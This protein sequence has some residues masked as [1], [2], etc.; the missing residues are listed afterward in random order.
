M[1]IL[2]AGLLAIAFA[3]TI[4]S[5]IYLVLVLLAVQPSNTPAAAQSQSPPISVLKP[6]HGLEPGLEHNLKS[7]F[8]QDYPGFEIIFGVRALSDPALEA[9]TRLSTQFPHVRVKVVAGGEPLWPSARAWSVHRMIPEAANEIL[10]IT[11]SDVRVESD[12]LK[13]VHAPLS[14]AG[15]V[16][17]LY[18]GLPLGGFW[19]HLEA[20]GMSVELMSG[21]LVANMLE[22]MKFA[23]GPATA[24][25]KQA[26]EAIGGMEEPGRHFADDFV[27]GGRM[28]ASGRA[29][30]L[31]DH[32]VEHAVPPCS[33]QQSFRHQLLWAKSS[34][35]SR[36]WGHIGSGLTFAMPYAILGAAVIHGWVALAWVG[37]GAANRILQCLAAGW[38]VVRDPRAKRLCWLYPVRD[39]L[40]WFVWICSFFGRTVYFRGGKYRLTRTGSLMPID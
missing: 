20:L 16:T 30:V 7:F 5:S 6:L 37:L 8:E 22:G 17:C 40:G 29:V 38:G 39:L 1:H 15:L 10:V 25:T 21:V 27:L 28:A 2:T 34:R 14:S 26:L 19:S 36:P 24:T 32:V 18:R 4:A 23:L 33:F 11:D 3:G 13:R 35:F 9:V 31:S 12:F